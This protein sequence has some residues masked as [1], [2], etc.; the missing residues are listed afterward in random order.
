[1]FGSYLLEIAIGIFFLYLL[2]SLF[3]SAINE[4]ISRI[5]KLRA[6]NL[7]EGIKNLLDDPGFTAYAKKVYDHALIKGLSKRGK[8]PSYIPSRIFASAVMDIVSPA[9]RYLLLCCS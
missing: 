7:R 1:M 6:N 2:L 8:L 5:F 9:L 3:C 4:W